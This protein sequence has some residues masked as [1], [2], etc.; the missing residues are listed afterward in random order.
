MAWQFGGPRGVGRVVSLPVGRIRVNPAQPRRQFDP[1][2]IEELAQSI[3]ANGLLQPITVRPVGQ[4][5]ELVSGQRRLMACRSLGL[6]EIPAILSSF[7]DRDSAVLALVENLHRADLTFWEEAQA[8]RRLMEEH[9]L[10]QQQA[11]RLLCRS[12]PAIANKLR[13]LRLPPEACETLCAAGLGERHARALLALGDPEEILAAARQIA[14]EGMTAAQAEHYVAH[15][16]EGRPAKGPRAV[17]VR[18]VRLLFNTISRA[19]EVIRQSGFAVEAS[20]TDDDDYLCY[21]VR[22]PRKD[23]CR[24]G[25]GQAR[26]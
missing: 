23:A 13:L 20:R 15:L 3:A 19:V 26:S 2:G 1:H 18:D 16:T 6:G 4:D 9:H 5:W 11:A 17:V 21:L 8:I 10:T 25:P 12:Q 14:A 22:I 7:S 24:P